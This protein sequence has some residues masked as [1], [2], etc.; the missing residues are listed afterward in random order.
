MQD[1]ESNIMCSPSGN[2][3]YID[4]SRY[5]DILNACR[6]VSR[7]YVPNHHTL[8]HR[9]LLISGEISDSGEAVRVRVCFS[10]GRG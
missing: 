6:N 5:M 3:Y 9:N 2:H 10:A 4:M 8:S 1:R 7:T